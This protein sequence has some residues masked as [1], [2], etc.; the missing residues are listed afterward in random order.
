MATLVAK[1]TINKKK[2]N[3]IYYETTETI[4]MKFHI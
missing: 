1:A 2:L 3:E 4:L